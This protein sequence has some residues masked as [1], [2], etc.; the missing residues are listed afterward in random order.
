MIR[1]HRRIRNLIATVAAAAVAL[2]LSACAAPAS[3]DELTIGLTYTPNIQF[4]PIYVAQELGYFDEAGVNVQLRHHGESEALFGALEGGSEHLVYAAGDE[5]LQGAAGG[6]PVVAVGTLYTEY[7]AVL[8]VPADSPIESAA[9]LAGHSVGVP[10]P[11]GETWFALQ[12]LLTDAGLDSDQVQI[13]HIGYTQQAALTS[14][15]VDAVMGFQ[16]NDAVQFEAAGFKVRTIAAVDPDAPQL[17]GPAIGASHSVLDSRG[18]DVS[19]ALA[20]IQRGVEYTIEHP[21]EAVEI[22]AKY[23]PTLSSEDARENALATL[24]ATNELMQP[25]AGQPLLHNDVETWQRM[26]EFMPAAKLI[27]GEIDCAAAYRNDLLP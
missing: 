11:Y 10:G 12:A 26:C 16:N 21:E 27:S 20:A 25:V 22:A 15:K 13:E 24:Q 7:P 6:V 1:I 5:I 14:G 23:I 2:T 17:V 18:D 9:D 4:A 19:A 8:I 3:N